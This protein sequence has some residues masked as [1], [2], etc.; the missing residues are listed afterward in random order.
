M[1]DQFYGFSG[2]PFQLTPDARF[3]FESGTHR[4]AMSYLGYGLAQGEGFIVITGEIGSGKSTLVAYLMDTIDKSRLNAVQL[5]STRVG[6]DDLLRLVAQQFELPSEGVSKAEL[7]QSIEFYLH[8]Q[9]RQGK[10]S[11]LIVDE[12]Q[13]LEE[14]ALE[15]LRMLS[16]FQLGGHPLLQI[17][18][19]GQPEFRDI[20]QYSPYLEQLRQRVIA[21]HHLTAMEPHEIEPYIMHRL[22]KVGWAG[23]PRFVGDAYYEMYAYSQGIPRKLNVLAS[24]VLLLGALEGLHEFNG[25]DIRAV[26]DDMVGDAGD[27]D[28]LDLDIEF[29]APEFDAPEAGAA[30]VAFAPEPAYAPATVAP[31]QNGLLATKQKRSGEPVLSG[32]LADE[33]DSAEEEYDEEFYNASGDQIDFV[34]PLTAV[35]P[36]T[37]SVDDLVVP[38][39]GDDAVAAP[40]VANASVT[41]PPAASSDVTL[42]LIS[43][44]Q[45][46]M[47]EMARKMG[48]LQARLEE[49]DVALRKMLTLLVNWVEADEAE[50]AALAED[51]MVSAA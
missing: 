47:D 27:E 49:Q 30:N 44:Q 12:A 43:Q 13:N 16:N 32:A 38:H 33:F 14:G 8:D 50:A 4:K 11:L 48:E 51:D 7:L 46:E 35:A 25:A 31:V 24:R 2:R 1:Y 40:S 42:D 28:P 17:F 10:R 23:S 6:G 39:G 45:E 36:P 15:E 22:T 9:A 19:L 37:R 3:Y 26:V 5:V 21:T 18:L 34:D 41:A 20:V 29:D